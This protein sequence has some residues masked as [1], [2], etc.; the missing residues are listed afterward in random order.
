MGG[1]HVIILI[2]SESAHN[3]LDPSIVKRGQFKAKKE[4]EIK[5]RVENSEQFIVRE[6][7]MM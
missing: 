1:Q 6:R 5:V 4:E 2:D 3:F 7:L